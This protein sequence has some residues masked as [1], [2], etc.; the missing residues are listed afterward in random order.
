MSHYLAF[1]QL[2][3]ATEI[4]THTRWLYVR[5]KSLHSLH[6]LPAIIF[7]G[8]NFRCKMYTL[9]LFLHYFRQ[10]TYSVYYEVTEWMREQFQAYLPHKSEK[11]FILI[12]SLCVHEVQRGTN[13]RLTVDDTLR[14]ANL[15]TQ[16]YHA[17][18]TNTRKTDKTKITAANVCCM[19][20][21]HFSSHLSYYIIN[22]R[23]AD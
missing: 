1:S 13:S 20:M 23:V 12:N 9:N 10:V 21:T 2:S 18:P 11:T 17:H 6:S 19:L 15:V 8:L 3:T 16:E 7:E 4:A 22:S 14:S 5:L